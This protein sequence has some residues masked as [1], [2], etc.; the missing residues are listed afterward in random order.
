MRIV[1][2]LDVLSGVVVHGV[3]GRRQEYRPI[4]SR[5]TTLQDPLSVALA[6]RENLK[7][8][9]LYVAD[10]DGIM[11]QRPSLTTVR[12]LADAKF[13]TMVDA[14]LRDLALA[15]ELLNAGAGAVVAGSETLPDPKLLDEL[16]AE[17]GPER[18][19]F[20]LDMKA[21]RLLG[22]LPQWA[23]AEPYEIAAEAIRRGIRRLIVLD[24]AQ[25]GAG[26][27]TS[28]AALCRQLLKAFPEVEL[29]TGGGIRGTSDVL[30]L[31]DAGVAAVLV[32]SALHD[33]SLS[34][35]DIARLETRG[36]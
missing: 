2:V 3:G 8:S 33:G 18:I 6:F 17:I 24:L 7:L 20:S 14:G 32:A 31:H 12:R 19:V 10:L 30:A 9:D 22:D 1:S 15:R 16:C 28:T 5:L 4:Q 34:G 26:R 21:G 36:A 29:I 11:D 27:G 25:V 13:V 23:L 35:Q